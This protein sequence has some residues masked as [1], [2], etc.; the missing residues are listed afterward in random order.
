MKEIT[1]IIAAYEQAEKQGRKTALATVVRVEG[2]SYR[3]PGARMLVTDDGSLTGAISGGCLESD[4][5]RKAL[6][7]IMQDTPLLVSYRTTDEEDR[8][9]GISLGCNGIIHVLIEPVDPADPHHP[10]ALLKKAVTGKSPVVL[11]TLFSPAHHRDARQGSCLVAAMDASSCPA[12]VSVT[13]AVSETALA[14]RLSAELKQAFDTGRSRLATL[15]MGAAGA[16]GYGGMTAFLQYIPRQISL[17]IAGAGADV[18]PVVQMASVMGWET[19][20]IDGRPRYGASPGF[21]PC[22][23]ILAAP[24][25]AVLE[26]VL[27]E[28][29]ACLLMSHNYHYDKAMMSRLAAYPVPYIGML[30][31]RKKKERMLGE[32]QKEGVRF[33]AAQLACI[34]SPAGLDIGAE[35]PQEI[36]CSIIAEIS[37]VFSGRTGRPLKD[38]SGSVHGLVAAPAEVRKKTEHGG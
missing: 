31:P 13:A 28:R 9:G 19:T 33:T 15:D 22:Q 3:A 37:M 4:A 16:P 12:S 32:L 34:H 17:V 36:A 1:Q 10:V 20:L 30:G 18:L 5:L 7:V 25:D 8:R 24:E 21:A 6:M 2:S 11:V 23:I 29:S 27:H 26:P 14:A 35:T 38:F